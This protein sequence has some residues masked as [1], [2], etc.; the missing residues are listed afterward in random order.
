[1]EENTI[2]QRYR[3]A[4]SYEPR[5]SPWGTI[6][7]IRWM[8]NGVYSVSTPSHGGI[9][10]H[11]K[12]VDRVLSKEAQNCGFRSGPFLCFEEDCDAPVVIRELLDL[13]IMKAPVNEYYK[14]EAYSAAI[15]DSLKRWHPEYWQAYEQR[16]HNGQSVKQKKSEDR[17]E[18]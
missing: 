3:E 17:E 18:R 2:E 6:D 15:N 1:M 5:H 13:G 9:M 16:L 10:I 8:A 11:K 4:A 12:I 7:G 14:E